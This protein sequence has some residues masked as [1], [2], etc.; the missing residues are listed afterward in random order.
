MKKPVLLV[1]PTLC[2]WLLCGCFAQ[3]PEIT[4]P[5]QASPTSHVQTIKPITE[6]SAPAQTS[7]VTAEPSA[8]TQT[9]EPTPQPTPAPT[10]S[11]GPAAMQYED[12]KAMW[13]SQY[14]LLDIYTEDGSQ[15][16]IEDFTARM[17]QVLD[18]VK[19][20]SFNTV[21]LQ[22]RPFADSMYPSQFY[23]MSSFVVGQIGAETK[24]DPVAITVR[25]AHERDLSIH[26]WI[27]P[28]RGM[29]EKELEL[30]G[31][32]YAIRRWYDDP[33]LRGKYIVAV[34][35]R[36]YLNP[37]YEEVRELICAGAE[38]TLRL[39]DFDGLHMDDYFYPTTEASFD[40]EAYAAYTSGGGTVSLADFRRNNVNILVESL[41]SLTHASRDGR[42]FGI[43]PGGNADTAY[44]SQ[45]ADIYTWCANEGYLDYICP[46][47]YFGLE[48][49]SYAFVK[50]CARFQDMIKTDSVDLIIGMT[51]GKAFS[52]ADQWAGS[53][54]DE[55]KN[56]DDVLLR[57][58]QTT[59]NLR[60]C[61]GVA[62]FC[63]QYFYEPLSGE[64]VAETA[65]ER[66]N[67]MSLFR[68]IS[69]K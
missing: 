19:D 44:N 28:L 11:E 51:F 65:A 21:F 45:Y 5:P 22:I 63:Y 29:Y 26:A 14:D 20:E 64:E 23:P 55:W 13:L 49:G 39:Y 2:L 53:G 68:E 17:A 33:D 4:T 66:E 27:N 16:D 48:H 37:A 38:E 25:L 60:D 50:V 47:V 35:G 3:Q 7:D 67:F 56:N 9:P 24:Y 46:Q 18:N 15:R 69:W 40:A 62:V 6:P 32:E 30:V 8:P 12:M 61:R 36:W 54:K 34:G 42:I 1:V 43:S 58:L 59:L 57:S 52:K 31:Q 10:P 41:Y